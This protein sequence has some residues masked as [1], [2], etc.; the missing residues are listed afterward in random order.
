MKKVTT[1]ALGSLVALTA[2]GC[3]SEPVPERVAIT[4]D[5]VTLQAMLYADN[6]VINDWDSKEKV[7]LGWRAE[8]SIDQVQDDVAG[9]ETSPEV[10]V[11][12]FGHNYWQDFST[13]RQMVLRDLLQA[14]H[15]DACVVAVM[16]WYTG[17]N[18]THLAR[19][20]Q[21][22]LVLYHQSTLS[23]NIVLVDWKSIVDANPGYHYFDG[24][25]LPMGED[26]TWDWE[27]PSSE[28]IEAGNAY[29]QVM[30]DGV[31]ACYEEV[32]PTVAI[33]VEDS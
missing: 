21:V 6:G 2:F 19:I 30:Q 7:M 29:T 13:E 31:D 16:P 28:M 22:R 9:E 33:R 11:V 3:K 15:E 32:L 1:L 17:P 27:N 8:H 18:E 20:E 14:P 10:L 25:H 24:V 26:D 23:N 4:G 12:A 5:S